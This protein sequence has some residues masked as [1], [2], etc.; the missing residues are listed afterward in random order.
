MSERLFDPRSTALVLI[1]LQHGIVGLPTAPYDGPLVTSK[2]AHLAHELRQKGAL[3]VYV[4]VDLQRMLKVPCDKSLRDPNAPP[5]PA[6]ASEIVPE[7]GIQK[8]DLVITKNQWGAFFGTDLEAQ[9]R[10]RQIKT[11]ILGGIATN[12]GVESTARA[13]AGLGFELITV[14]DICTSLTA[15]GHAFVFQ[16]IFPLISR[17]RRSDEILAQLA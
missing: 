4:R 13:A 3:I 7:S 1:D 15:E 17:V 14:E 8:E 2:S 12:F 11:V 5:P 10:A 6:H 16:N 9:L